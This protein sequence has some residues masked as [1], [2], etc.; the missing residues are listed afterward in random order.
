MEPSYPFYHKSRS[1][2]KNGD[3]PERRRE[4]HERRRLL[5]QFARRTF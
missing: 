3:A 4:D 2:V 5:D 1:E